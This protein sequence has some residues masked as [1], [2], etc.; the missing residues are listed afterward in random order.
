MRAR[1]AL[2]ISLLLLLE[3]GKTNAQPPADA[4]A[5]KGEEEEVAFIQSPYRIL[6]VRPLPGTPGVQTGFSRAQYLVNFGAREGVKRGSVFQVYR[7][8][9]YIGLVQVSRTWRDTAYV[10]PIRL[11][12]RKDRE[13][14]FPLQP[15]YQLKPKYVT[16]ETIHFDSGK[17]QFSV[18][19]NERLHY[20]SRFINAF[21]DFPLILEGH[22]DNTGDPKKNIVLAQQRA[23]EIKIFLNEIHFIPLAQMHTT[24]LGDSDPVATNA[25]DE[26]RLQNRR[27]DIILMDAVPK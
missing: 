26:G 9:E 19:M 23:A 27:V 6:A 7:I 25:T 20:A 15:G 21:P 3:L 4:T 2:L 22:T 17:P 24:G 16:L 18:E 5:P 10:R 12:T 8:T 1:M 13:A 11:E 14:L